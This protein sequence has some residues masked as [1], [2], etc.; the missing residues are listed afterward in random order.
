[1][2]SDL[3]ESISQHLAILE[4][5]PQADELVREIERELAELQNQLA[6][7]LSESEAE[8]L[9]GDAL[10]SDVSPD[11]TE[12]D[13][14]SASDEIDIDSA[15]PQTPE[16]EE[17]RWRWLHTAVAR[18]LPRRKRSVVAAMVATALLIASAI[19]GAVLLNR[20]EG[21]P[22]GVAFQVKGRNVRQSKLSAE[23]QTL[24]ALY[25]I[26]APTSA[27]ALDTFHRN[28]AKAYA[29]SIVLDDAV[30]ARHIVIA[31]KQ[32]QDVLARYLQEQFGNSADV[33]TQ[34]DTALGQVGTSETAVLAEI[35]RQLAISQLYD[36][37]TAAASVSD[38]E[39]AAQFAKDKASL[40]TPEQRDIH[41]IVV[42][43]EATARALLVKLAHGGAFD[44]LAADF[45]LDAATRSK[46]GDLGTV[47]ASDL[48]AGYAKV[49]FAAKTGVPFGPIKTQY[50]WNV[51]IVTKVLPATAAEYAKIKDGLHARLVLN[52]QLAL[53]RTWIEGQIRAAR[54]RYAAAFLPADP[55]SAPSGAPGSPALGAATTPAA[56]R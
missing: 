37:V 17:G 27:T 6:I 9:S 33:V 26:Q 24:G 49:A 46:G 36:Q 2:I 18:C 14:L 52:K 20:Q 39:V 29:V 5:A 38:A 56:G 35:K 43:S 45:S 7:L 34:F 19:T 28:A 21:L 32:A 4:S 40:A 22:S 3:I 11:D 31:D 30:Q 10:D 13:Q 54:V 48:E 47:Q 23:V 8:R 44:T 53:W 25:G 12:P 15:E 1:M 41:N 16:P 51:A 50:G 55:D 42:Q